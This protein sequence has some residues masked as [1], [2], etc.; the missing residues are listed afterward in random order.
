[1]SASKRLLVAVATILLTASI[2]H[3]DCTGKV[4][5][6][7]DGDTLKVL[8][9]KT[10]IKVRLYGIDAP[11]KKQA[12]GTQ[13]KK[14]TSEQVFG[15]EVELIEKNKDMYGRTVG[16]IK[17]SSGTVLNEELLKS[18]FVWHYKQYSKD[19]DYAAMEQEARKKKVGLWID[20]KAQAPWDYRKDE[21][22]KRQLKKKQ[23]KVETP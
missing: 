7:S 18:G 4:V 21:K 1:M 5:G 14:F 11:E 19:Q 3:A 17:Y 22:K 23:H 6:V 15:K 16:I 20:P 8:C 2:A 10:P 9:D 12:F 13:A